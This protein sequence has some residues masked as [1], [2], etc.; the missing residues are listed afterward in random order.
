MP[1]K[2]TQKKSKSLFQKLAK[3]HIKL[4]TFLLITYLM[5]GMIVDPRFLVYD[6]RQK[7][8]ALASSSDITVSLRVMGQPGKPIVNAEA[9]WESGISF[10]NLTW[11]QTEDTETYDVYRDALPLITG[12]VAN[13]YRDTNIEKN[14]FYDY[15][16]LAKGPMGET[17]SDEIHIFSGDH[18]I[19]SLP[20]CQIT[21]INNLPFNNAIKTTNRT[22]FFSGTTNI[23]NGLVRIELNSTNKI[24]ATTYANANGYWSWNSTEKLEYGKHNIIIT[25]TDPENSLISAQTLKSFE[26]IEKEKSEESENKTNQKSSPARVTP[27]ATTHESTLQ[28]QPTEEQLAPKKSSFELIV[29]VS[30]PNHLVYTDDYL[31][32]NTKVVTTDSTLKNKKIKLHY[33]I[34]DEKNNSIL[35]FLEDSTLPENKIIQKNIHISELFPAGKYKVM[36]R[37]SDDD[38]LISGEDFFQVKE[39]YL[40]SLGNIN[41]TLS[42]IMQSLSWIIFFLLLLILFFLFMLAL[43]KYLASQAQ[44][45]ITEY[46]LAKRGYFG[47]RKGVRK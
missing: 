18:E 27:P 16:V 26:I 9:D 43:E 14:T 30:N 7:Y 34:S 25:I 45:Q 3:F 21:T 4:A 36:V 29:S 33:T 10:I 40:I 6:F 42:Q 38:F 8:S 46:F 1:K 23:K 28:K 31:L 41:I 47:N 5:L 17:F 35:D 37:A 32:V 20:F 22:P 15:K 11:N 2:K 44:R 39:Y 24:T 12:L 13:S 19:Y